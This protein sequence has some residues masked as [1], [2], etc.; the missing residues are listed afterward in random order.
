M[1]SAVIF[2]ALI[3]CSL[4]ARSFELSLNDSCESSLTNSSGVCVE[5]KNCRSFRKFKNQ[6]NICAFEGKIPI[7]CCPVSELS[8][9]QEMKRKSAIGMEK[10]R[11]DVDF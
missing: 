7:V 9:R 8:S 1:I 2:S 4:G 5:P 6:L 10:T 11:N 3:S